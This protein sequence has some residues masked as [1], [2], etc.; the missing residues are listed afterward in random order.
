MISEESDSESIKT[1]SPSKELSPNKR[2]P[3]HPKTRESSIIENDEML[4]WIPQV[5]NQKVFKGVMDEVLIDYKVQSDQ[6]LEKRNKMMQHW[7][8]CAAW[9]KNQVST[10]LSISKAM[11]LRKR[12]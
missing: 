3:N 6:E 2:T 10:D 11:L 8:K 4:P 7:N 12:F 5:C 1:L 9:R